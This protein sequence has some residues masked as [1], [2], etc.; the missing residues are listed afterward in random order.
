MTNEYNMQARELSV[1]HE[2]SASSNLNSFQVVSGH[3][4]DM[5]GCVRYENE[6]ENGGAKINVQDE[7]LGNEV[8]IIGVITCT[9]I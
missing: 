5:H 2:A 8:I 6:N 7:G 3:G 1:R 4:N 9:G